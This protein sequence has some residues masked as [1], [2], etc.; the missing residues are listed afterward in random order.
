MNGKGDTF[1]KVDGPKYRQ[2]HDDIF[3]PKGEDW[4]KRKIS[5]EGQWNNINE[6]PSFGNSPINPT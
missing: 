3:E 2:N 6:F 5:M 4:D 1:R